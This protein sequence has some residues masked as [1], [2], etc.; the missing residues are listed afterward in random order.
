MEIEIVN[1]EMSGDPPM[2]LGCGNLDRKLATKSTKFS[3]ANE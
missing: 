2:S 1:E 3:V